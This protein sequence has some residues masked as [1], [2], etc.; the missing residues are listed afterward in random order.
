MT[1]CAVVATLATVLFGPAAGGGELE[2]GFRTPPA[3]CRPMAGWFHTPAFA[4]AVKACPE[5]VRPAFERALAHGGLSATPEEIKRMAAWQA[6]TDVGVIVQPGMHGRPP[7]QP[8]DALAEPLADFTARLVHVASKT[9]A[10]GGVFTQSKPAHGVTIYPPT[11]CLYLARRQLGQTDV[12]LAVSQRKIDTVFTM[13][14][15]RLAT[16]EIWDPEDGSIRD[17]LAYA[18]QGK[19]TALNLRLGPYQALFIVLRKPPSTQ[20]VMFA[21]TLRITSVAPDGSSVSGLAR[22]K[23]RC[24]VMFANGTMRTAV[25]KDLPPPLVLSRG[26]SLVPRSPAKRAGVGIVALRWRRAGA[27]ERPA[28][29]AAPD[30]DDSAWTARELGKPQQAPVGGAQWQANWLTFEGAPRERLF[31]KTFD[32]PEQPNLA[33]VTLTGDN[34]YELFVNGQ[35]LGA[36][37]GPAQ[38]WKKAE[39]YDALKALHKGR[40]VLAVRNT[41]AGGIGGLLLESRIRLASGAL[42]RI[43]TDATWT[44]AA[45]APKG[46]EAVDFDDSKWQKPRVHGKP[47]I[48]P[49]GVPAGLP[50]DPAAGQL[51]WCRFTLPAGARAVQLPAGL[52]D[53]KLFVDG[54]PVALRDGAADLSA[55]VAKRPVVA[56]LRTVGIAA[57][58]KPILCECA[59]GAVGV[60]NWLLVGYPTY[61][62]LADYTVDFDLPAAYAKERLVLDLGRVG[63]AAR[64]ALNGRDVGTRLWRPFLLD[65]ADAIRPGKNSLVITCANTAANASG[66]PIPAERQAAGILGPV[67]IRALRPVTIRSE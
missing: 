54:K 34:G 35:R 22:Q 66:Q 21:P 64:V 33:T 56:A 13:S 32:L 30:F 31:R 55:R 3:A 20:H 51:T 2:A 24:S 63:V 27:D 59:A 19:S 41:N 44:M 28:Q 17:A 39:T 65:V 29:W 57:F 16:P 8:Y 52:K 58:D 60:G 12:Y 47:P 49:W 15:P 5:E 67:A 10:V 11:S 37:L 38:D 25:V 7:S 6:L 50:D 36:E 53:P 14:V 42:V 46:W 26:W 48:Q 62:G 61:S 23:G 4:A 18:I 45:K 1:R 43:V 9:K 40:N